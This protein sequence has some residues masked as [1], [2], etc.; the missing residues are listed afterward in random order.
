MENWMCI[1]PWACFSN[2][3]PVD[4]CIEQAIA[5]L[6]EQVVRASQEDHKP[7]GPYLAQLELIRQ[8]KERKSDHI[9][10][11]SEFSS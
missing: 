8:L 7:R 3:E 10:K 5:F 4:C 11:L 9:N 6:E 1:L 2:E